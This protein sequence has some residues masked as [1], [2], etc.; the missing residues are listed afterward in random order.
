M[1]AIEANQFAMMLRIHMEADQYEDLLGAMV[2]I[3]ALKGLIIRVWSPELR[4]SPATT[5]NLR[6]PPAG[7]GNCSAAEYS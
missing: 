1:I 7:T 5:C 2:E 6:D 4:A 3:G